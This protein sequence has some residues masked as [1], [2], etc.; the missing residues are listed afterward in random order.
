[1]AEPP[2]VRKAKELGAWLIES[3]RE[4]VTLE[5]VLGG[6]LGGA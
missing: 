1:L 3:K 4:V 5:E 2:A 6:S